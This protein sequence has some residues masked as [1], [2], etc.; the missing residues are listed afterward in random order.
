MVNK[1]IKFPV[2]KGTQIIGTINYENQAGIF[3]QE[4]HLT[5]IQFDLKNFIERTKVSPEKFRE[6]WINDTLW[7]NH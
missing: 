5:S 3:Q 2:T 7:E 1:K 6:L 4:I